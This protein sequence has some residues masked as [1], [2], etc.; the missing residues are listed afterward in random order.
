VTKDGALVEEY[1]Y[2][3]NGARVS[4]MNALRGI[5]SRTMI[6]SDEDHLLTAGATTYQYD[7]DG[8]LLI[9]TKGTQ[10]TNYSYSS[11]G[12]LLQVVLPDNKT[13]E[14]LYDP[15]GRRIAK[16][17]NGTTTEKYLWRDLTQLLAVYDGSN[18]LLMRFEYADERLPAA[19]TSGGNTFYLTYDQVGSLRVVA[20]ASGNVVKRIDYDSFGNI[21]NDTSPSIIIPFGFAGGLEDRD[22]GLVHFGLRDYDPDIG[23][24]TA[25]DP[26]WFWG[27]NT[28][29]YGYCQNDPINL[30]DPQG[31]GQ[32][33]EE[34]IDWVAK[35][36]YGEFRGQG[37][38]YYEVTAWVI[39][40]RH[41]YPRK[42]WQT[43]KGVVT[44][45]WQ[46]SCFNPDDKNR[47]KVDNPNLKDPRWVSARSVAKQVL[48]AAE[49]ENPI[50]N[51]YNYYS[52]IS[53]RPAGSV[54]K[55]ARGAPTVD[56][57]GID[58]WKMTLIKLKNP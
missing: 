23:R 46:F 41:S 10:I 58:P 32:V 35:A 38:K 28:D 30:V 51:V 40:N 45:P 1:Q 13:I 50:P 57:E 56:V 49:C 14:Y 12:E 3:A 44:D 31:L 9:K 29:L 37:E 16:A 47:K 34:D 25:K 6:Y 5:S 26:V 17:I 48:N 33:T 52:P 8:Y 27:F 19:M 54:P 4:E 15:L 43:Y 53:R 20:D 11:V 7:A 39:R 21:I 2:G 18:N 36:L 42:R 22:T 24:W 55:W